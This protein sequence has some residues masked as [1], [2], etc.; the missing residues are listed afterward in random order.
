MTDT[1]RELTASISDAYA[2]LAAAAARDANAALAA[3]R[4]EDALAG[5]ELTASNARE[6]T[7]ASAAYQVARDAAR[8]V[9][10]AANDR[11]EAAYAAWSA[12]DRAHHYEMKRLKI[13]FALETYP[14][15]ASERASLAVVG[16]LTVYAAA[17]NDAEKALAI[18]EDVNNG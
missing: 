12:A 5:R 3:A 17:L 16:S 4:A 1:N 9:Y 18:A 10:D 14:L 13:R 11:A 8:A 15:A 7:A 6:L 2:A